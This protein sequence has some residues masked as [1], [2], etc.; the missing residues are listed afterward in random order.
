VNKKY[1]NTAKMLGANSMTA[2]LFGDACHDLANCINQDIRQK[3]RESIQQLFPDLKG[4]AFEM[5][6]V[7]ALLRQGINNFTHKGE[8]PLSGKYIISPGSYT[9]T[10]QN[11]EEMQKIR[12]RKP[13][14]DT[15]NFQDI[16]DYNGTKIGIKEEFKAE[17]EK[18]LFQPW[19]SD[20]YIIKYNHT[21]G[22][23]TIVADYANH[24]GSTLIARVKSETVFTN[25][26]KEKPAK[27]EAST[28]MDEIALMEINGNRM[29]LPSSIRFKHYTEIKRILETA[30]GKYKNNGFVFNSDAQEIY[31]RLMGG[32]KVNDKKKFQFYAT[33]E[34]MAS[35]VIDFACIQEGDLVLEPSAG[36]GGIADFIPKNATVEVVEIMEANRKVLKEK[37]YN[38][39]GDD[40]LKLEGEKVYDKI[41]A[42]PPFT[43]NQDIKH[44]K[45]MYKLLK[46]GGTV[47]C[48]MSTGW[49]Y[50]YNKTHI[51][52]RKWLGLQPYYTD[53]QVRAMANS[54]KPET[55]AR[56]NE[57][58]FDEQ[59]LIQTFKE[60]EFKES[61][62]NVQTCIVVINKT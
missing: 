27:P 26:E 1:A 30:G 54:Y 51:E 6:I 15:D 22:L 21:N 34:K 7:D 61:G 49:L 23:T 10:N 4:L 3:A 19:K 16:F 8:L 62:T 44:L 42:N 20:A 13:I 53:V 9:L 39:V 43:N 11:K 36:Q 14:F 24:I 31:D 50:N 2:T 48:I 55:F 33:L 35:K 56:Q 52:F 32:E 5:D 17:Y 12:Q 29:D 60:G 28:A 47:V 58:R 25:V 59:V 57:D 18:A 45:H 40:F 38:L 37:G 41:V 46:E